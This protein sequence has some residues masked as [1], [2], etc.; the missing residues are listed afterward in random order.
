MPPFEPSEFPRDDLA[1]KLADATVQVVFGY[2]NS[3][4]DWD[5]QRLRLHEGLPDQFRETALAAAENL[6]DE[7][8]GRDYDPEWDLKSDE[9]LY[10]SND[11]PVGGDFF[12]QLPN[13]GTFTEFQER[14]RI[15]QPN[16]WLVIAQ[17]S[18]DT[19]AYFGARITRSLVL[20]RTSRLLRVV[21]R[22]EAFDALDET[23]ITFRPSFDWI[24]WQ[25]TLIVLNT[26]GFHGTFRDIPALVAKVDEHLS[27][28]SE[29][30]G[31]AN[32]SDFAERIKSYP[33]MMVKLQR[34]VE[35]A[36]MHTR[37]PEVLRKYGQE[38]AIDVDWNGDQMVFDGSVEKQWNILRLLDEAR[39]LGPVTGKHWDTSSK[40]EV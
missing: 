12:T 37:D 26:K 21:Y 17:L 15:R 20:E 23:V 36:D 30:V 31:I 22:D 14:R 39:T 28:V 10:L 8:V 40:T 13:F 5:F 6:R 34:I 27:A 35:R 3:P 9:F 4:T 2:K 33:A 16:I 7:R 29:H 32:L 38:Y 18:D 25:D 19:L 11:P 1:T 24:A